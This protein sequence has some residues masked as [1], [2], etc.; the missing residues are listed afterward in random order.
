[1]G[2]NTKALW[3]IVGPLVVARSEYVMSVKK[4]E[5]GEVVVNAGKINLYIC[6]LEK[7]KKK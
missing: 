6:Q 2:N 4:K 3:I 1:M 5:I 7:G